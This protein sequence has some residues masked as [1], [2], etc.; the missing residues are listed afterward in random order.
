MF[1]LHN[2][3]WPFSFQ[4]A[5]YP[6]DNEWWIIRKGIHI[7]PI[8]QSIP[9]VTLVAWIVKW[10]QRPEKM[11]PFFK[12]QETY[13]VI[14]FFGQKHTERIYAADLE[15]IIL[16][17]LDHTLTFKRKHEKKRRFEFEGD[18]TILEHSLR[19]TFPNVPL[20]IINAYW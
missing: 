4:Y 10:L 18:A 19:A 5:C 2:R 9:G 1:L 7:E 13:D 15:A 8:Y 6:K 12:Q 16:H 20:T 14:Q 3:S 11:A 17:T